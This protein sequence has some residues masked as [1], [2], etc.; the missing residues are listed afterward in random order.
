MPAC[1]EHVCVQAGSD[2]SAGHSREGHGHEEAWTHPM[3]CWAIQK[4]VDEHP[5]RL[6]MQEAQQSY[7]AL[8][9]KVSQVLVSSEAICL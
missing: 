1:G 8:C 9:H 7:T 2:R 3:P 6:A 4:H 5:D